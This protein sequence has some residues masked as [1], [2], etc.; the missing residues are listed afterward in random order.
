MPGGASFFG[1]FGSG[2]AEGGVLVPVLNSFRG[3]C[4]LIAGSAGPDA[5][6]A[7]VGSIAALG[8]ADGVVVGAES[9]GGGGGGAD[10][11]GGAGAV[12]AA[13]GAGSGVER[14]PRK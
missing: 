1:T 12:V 4:V 3:P 7:G 6:G 10:I 5:D 13:G 2:S 11:V 9:I 14:L 8:S